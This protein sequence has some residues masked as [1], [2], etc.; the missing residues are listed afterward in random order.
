MRSQ[1]AVAHG[2]ALGWI[3]ELRRLSHDAVY[4]LVEGG[5]LGYDATALPA[6]I[7]RYVCTW[8]PQLTDSVVDGLHAIVTRHRPFCDCSTDS[9]PHRCQACLELWPCPDYRDATR[10]VTGVV[11]RRPTE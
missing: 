10:G 11:E 9:H 2:V 1:R 7:R 8:V 5:R 3:A 6:P 4:Y